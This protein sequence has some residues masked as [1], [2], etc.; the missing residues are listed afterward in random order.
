MSCNRGEISIRFARA[1]SELGLQTVAIYSKEDEHSL[2]RYKS[3]Q[4]FLIGK[5]K[6]HCT[7]FIM[8]H[9]MCRQYYSEFTF[10]M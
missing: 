2:H 4:A 5:D 6:V 8:N 9:K 7:S 10:C 1:G 3:D